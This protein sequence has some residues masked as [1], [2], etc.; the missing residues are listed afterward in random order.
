M[1]PTAAGHVSRVATMPAASNTCRAG[2]GHGRAS[3]ERNLPPPQSQPLCCAQ[4]LQLYRG[5]GPCAENGAQGQ[6]R[7]ET[8]KLLCSWPEKA[9]RC[10]RDVCVACASRWRIGNGSSAVECL[11]TLMVTC[12]EHRRKP[13]SGAMLH[14]FP[15]SRARLEAHKPAQLKTLEA[16]CAMRR[17]SGITRC[18]WPAAPPAQS[19]SHTR[20]PR[21]CCRGSPLPACSGRASKSRAS[22]DQ[23]RSA[24]L[25]WTAPW[26][27][28]L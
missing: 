19:A 26:G 13:A 6:R 27:G 7:G 8:C 18:A 14:G 4:Q 12:A 9:G 22:E 21:E 16:C 15:P 28:A 5:V 23:H 20:W 1:P 2:A 24:G 11:G 3:G 10:V 17:W 25:C